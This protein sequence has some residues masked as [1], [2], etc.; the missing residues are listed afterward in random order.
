MFLGRATEQGRVIYIDTEERPQSL[1][2]RIQMQGQGEIPPEQLDIL[3]SVPTM[4][5]AEF[6]HAIAEY[7]GEKAYDDVRLIIVDTFSDIDPNNKK[8]TE[9]D[10]QYTRGIIKNL[11]SLA[12]ELDAS[13]LIVYHDRK[14]FD[15]ERPF[16]NILGSTGIY[17]KVEGA[18]VLH[19]NNEFGDSATLYQ[20][21][22]SIPRAMY[23]T[24][25]S[26]TDFQWSDLQN[27]ET[28]RNDDAAQAFNSDPIAKT[29]I[30]ML[31]ECGGTKECRC[32]EI[33]N[34]AKEYGITITDSKKCIEQKL[35]IKPNSRK[36]ECWCWN[37]TDEFL[38][39]Q[40]IYRSN[41]SFYRNFQIIHKVFCDRNAI[42]F[43]NIRQDSNCTFTDYIGTLKIE[44]FHLAG[45]FFRLC[46]FFATFNRLQKLVN[47]VLRKNFI[48]HVPILR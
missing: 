21:G 40:L 3:F 9:N 17:S 25:F 34:K 45:S 27:V 18:L 8:A 16:A 19:R 37:A 28:M 48:A 5:K 15:T 30:R 29:V 33:V 31:S 43:Q 46:I 38:A 39:G 36:R 24:R 42:F 13:I 12:K 23:G 44:D 6:E 32:T 2:E 26:E 7:I 41:M 4:N 20:C 35:S 10:Y 47:L 1:V 11:Q 22:K 14:Q